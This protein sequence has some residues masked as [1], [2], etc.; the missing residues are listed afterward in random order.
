MSFH[1]FAKKV[2]DEDLCFIRDYLKIVT[3]LLNVVPTA[4][5]QLFSEKFAIKHNLV[6]KIQ[7]YMENG[8]YIIVDYYPSDIIK[9]RERAKE[10]LSIP[11]QLP[12]SFQ[13]ATDVRFFILGILKT[14]NFSNADKSWLIKECCFDDSIEVDDDNPIYKIYLEVFQ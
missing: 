1:F 14:M 13:E 4:V 3:R 11:K 7:E 5:L 2:K 10:L 12:L 8:H 9:K 6:D